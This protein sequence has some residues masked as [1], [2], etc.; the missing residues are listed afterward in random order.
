MQLAFAR[1]L[2]KRGRSIEEIMEYTDLS[3]A[4][5]LALRARDNL[6]LH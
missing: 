4:E 6:L 2:L 5:I 1:K 3:E